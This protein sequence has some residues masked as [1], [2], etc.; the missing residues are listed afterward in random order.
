MMQTKRIALLGGDARMHHLTELLVRDGWSVTSYGC[1]V[2]EPVSGVEY[3]ENARDA[4]SD[5]AVVVLPLPILGAD[6]NLNA[7][8][9]KKTD[10]YA[11]LAQ[12]PRGCLVCG[13]LAPADYGLCAARHGLRLVDYYE[14]EEFAV[15]NCVPTAE[16]AIETAMRELPVTLHGTRM[17]VIGWGRVGKA[18]AIRLHALGAK[19]TVSARKPGALAEIAAFGMTAV[20]TERL[21]A[22]SGQILQN[23]RVIFNTVPWPVLGWDELAV[24]SSGALYIELA[25]APGGLDAQA[26]E[27]TALHIIRAPGLPGIVAPV[28]AAEV[29]RDTLYNIWQ[30]QGIG[31]GEVS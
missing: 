30:E 28:T 7:D 25:S 29:L 8:V 18:L 15:A 26:A 6:G 20:H 5:A 17:L 12:L 2:R 21:A 1:K 3:A 13:G 27:C 11:L 31:T 23:A 10:A 16:G 4:A 14:R 22:D 9:D 24:M 19:V